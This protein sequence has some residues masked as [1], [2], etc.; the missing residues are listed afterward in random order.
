MRPRWVLAVLGLMV[1][2]TACSGGPAPQPSAAFSPVEAASGDLAALPAC[3]PPPAGSGETVEGLTAPE[4]T[5]VLKVEQGEPLTTVTGFSPMTPAQF[6]AEF[7]TMDDVSILLSENEVYEAE[8][9]VTNGSHRTFFKAT[10][11]C[12]RGSKLIAVVAP[13][14]DAE[15][16]PL[17]QGAVSATP[18]P[19]P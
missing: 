7:R 17:P 11:T 14:V 1:G 4:G 2:A 15:G 16:L 8:L 13:E 10:A 19:T 5:V 12:R 6:E 3:P 18:A 9:L